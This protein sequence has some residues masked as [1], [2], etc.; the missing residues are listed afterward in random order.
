MYEHPTVHKEPRC[1]GEAGCTY[2]KVHDHGYDCDK[3]CL[4]CDGQC[5]RLCPA[6][7]PY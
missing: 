6:H 7:V 4:A 3:K 2:Q 1:Q 5:H